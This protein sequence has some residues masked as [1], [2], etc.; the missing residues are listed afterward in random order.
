MQAVSR[1]HSNGALEANSLEN[2]D[3]HLRHFRRSLGDGFPVSRLKQADL[4]GHLSRRSQK[5]G[6]RNRKVSAVTLRKERA[7]S[8]ASGSGPFGRGCSGNE[9]S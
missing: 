6:I 1:V 4:Q 2:V 7:V 8:A 9:A 3:M 5:N